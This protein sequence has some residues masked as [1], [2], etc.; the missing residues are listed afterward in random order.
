M[1]KLLVAEVTADGT[2]KFTNIQTVIAYLHTGFNVVNTLIF[3]PFVYQFAALIRRL[4]PDAP[5]KEIPR[6]TVLDERVIETPVLA[7]HDQITE[8][9]KIIDDAINCDLAEAP[10]H[11]IHI[12]SESANI[13]ALIK[14]IREAQLHR[15]EGQTVEPMKVVVCMDMLSA[16][17]RIKENLLN[18]GETTS[19]GKAS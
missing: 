15:M 19:G 16:Y 3:I 7:V 10:N 2:E 17:A 9:C 4:V 11:L 13:K 5:V 14:K 8:F 18:I 12:G 6:L 1:E